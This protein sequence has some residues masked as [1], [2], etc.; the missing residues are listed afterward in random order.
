[1]KKALCCVLLAGVLAGCGSTSTLQADADLEPLPTT[2]LPV[3]P[4]H[5][6]MTAAEAS[7]EYQNL[8]VA[9][10]ERIASADIYHIGYTFFFKPVLQAPQAVGLH[11]FLQHQDMV[12]ARVEIYPGGTV[13]HIGGRYNVMPSLPVGMAFRFWSGSFEFDIDA[14]YYFNEELAAGIFIQT[15]SPLISGPNFY[16]FAKYAR[17]LSD[18]RAIFAEFGVRIN[19]AL[20]DGIFVKAEYFFNRYFSA[21]IRG[22]TDVF[23]EICGTVAYRFANGLGLNARIGA[24][25]DQ[26]HVRAGGEYRF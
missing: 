17:S 12:N 5:A 15:N 9:E 23:A 20:D 4:Y 16:I 25:G 22:S 2:L 10:Y 8:A 7:S 24:M 21:G 3:E 13:G 26:F 6:A 14:T 19:D 18:E 1:M 11:D